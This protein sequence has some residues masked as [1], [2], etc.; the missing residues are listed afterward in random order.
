MHHL[1]IAIERL[2]QFTV[3]TNV[4]NSGDFRKISKRDRHVV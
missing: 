3:F 2:L 1:S 4:L